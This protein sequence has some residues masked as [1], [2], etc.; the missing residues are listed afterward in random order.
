VK[1]FVCAK[2]ILLGHVSESG[3]TLSV[4]HI[5]IGW[6]KSWWKTCRSWVLLT[7]MILEKTKKNQ[8]TLQAHDKG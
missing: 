5:W 4:L 3:T 7:Q 2:L 8:V 1:K 6:K